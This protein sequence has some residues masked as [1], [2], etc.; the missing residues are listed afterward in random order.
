MP[1]TDTGRDAGADEKPAAAPR[2]PRRLL[3]SSFRRGYSRL[4]RP[5]LE[6]EPGSSSLPSYIALWQQLREQARRR[7]API[8]SIG[9][10]EKNLRAISANCTATQPPSGQPHWDCAY[11]ASCPPCDKPR[12]GYLLGGRTLL[13]GTW[14]DPAKA[15]N[16]RASTEPQA[17]TTSWPLPALPVRLA[18]VSPRHRSLPC[19]RPCIRYRVSRGPCRRRLP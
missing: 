6:A 16:P 12:R 2:A 3:C 14:A 19:R 10:Q 13:S 8:S 7:L 18:S 15:P 9:P 5:G 1:G 17:T 11:C 4:K